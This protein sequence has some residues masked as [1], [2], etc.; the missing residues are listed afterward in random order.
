MCSSYDTASFSQAVENS[1]DELTSKVMDMYNVPGMI[2][3]V[4]VPGEGT[5]VKA[6]GEKDIKTGQTMELYDKFRIGSNTKTFTTTLVLQLVDEGLLSLDDKLD[7][8]VDGVPGGDRITVR[9]L[10]NNTSGLFEYGD[11]EGL[12]NTLAAE[13]RKKW[14]PRELVDVAISHE[15][16]F[17]PGEGW[18]YSNTNF[19]LQGMII[20]K[21]T[22]NKL[23]EEYQ[24]RIFD[25]LRLN[26][27]SFPDTPEMTG[28]Y[29][30][31]YGLE[32][33]GDEELTD[34]T[35]YLDPSI[36]WAAG[37]IISNLDDLKVWA[38][39]LAGGELIS[40][41]MH[42]E[43]LTWVDIP[44]TEGIT[45]YGLGIFNIGGLIGHN[46]Q[47]PGYQSSVFYLPK[48]E[49]TIIVLLNNVTEQSLDLQVTMA[50]AEEVFPDDVS[51]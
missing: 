37:A 24:T 45:K 41:A 40:N 1:L 28:N 17:P 35:E 3:G 26:N 8:Y 20:E 11:D 27:T 38:K 25:E 19:I 14:T 6:K 32:Q 43:Q 46:G 2:V 34:F 4:W 36:H 31:G 50:I 13:P 42:K 44:G 12:V 15:P 48:K 23:A 47:T 39:A 30:H 49:A 7:E 9:Q 51:W 18:H 5:W 16:Y 29:S 10:C 22:G 21:V 33:E